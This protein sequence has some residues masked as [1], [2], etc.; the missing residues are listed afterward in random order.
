MVLSLHLC[1]TSLMPGLPE[2]W[3]LGILGSAAGKLWAHR[4]LGHGWLGHILRKCP[5]EWL[6]CWV[7]SW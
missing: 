1:K 2:T 3:L 5:T 7:S 6:W 4:G